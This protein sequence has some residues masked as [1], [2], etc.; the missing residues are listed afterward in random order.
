MPVYIEIVAL[1]EPS[2]TPRK[3]VALEPIDDTVFP[4]P[5]YPVLLNTTS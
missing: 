5:T 1:P 2:P 3:V 4:I